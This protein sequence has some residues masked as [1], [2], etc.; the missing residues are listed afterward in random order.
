MTLKKEKLSLYVHTISENNIHNNV[1]A[2]IIYIYTV[3]VNGYVAINSLGKVTEKGE[4][5]SFYRSTLI[6]Q[7]KLN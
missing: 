5:H 3:F 6:F 1:Y 2:M 4:F 7:T